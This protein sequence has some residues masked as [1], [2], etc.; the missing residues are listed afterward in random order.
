MNPCRAASRGIYR[1]MRV[2]KFDEA[3]YVLHCFRGKTRATGKPVKL[4]IG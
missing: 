1:L 3:V 4:A 2:A